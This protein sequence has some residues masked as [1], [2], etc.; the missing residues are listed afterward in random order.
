MI[1]LAT[2]TARQRF[3]A[4]YELAEVQ[5]AFNALEQAIWT[6]MFARLE[7]EQLVEALGSSTTI[8]G[9]GKDALAREYVSLVWAS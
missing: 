7:A 5:T 4:G 6:R 9:A 1:A 8:L 3:D 2:E